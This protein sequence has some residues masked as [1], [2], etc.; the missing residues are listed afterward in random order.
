MKNTSRW[1]GLAVVLALAWRGAVLW[2]VA[3]PPPHDATL[4]AADPE[5]ETAAEDVRPVPRRHTVVAGETLQSIAE[6]YYGDPARAADVREANREAI[7][8]EETLR[9]GTILT[10]P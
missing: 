3:A 9:P 6:Q 4:G 7:G 5:Y 1:I 8:G 10:L 2:D